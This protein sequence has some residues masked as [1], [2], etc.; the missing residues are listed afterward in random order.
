M[1]SSKDW[2]YVSMLRSWEIYLRYLYFDFLLLEEVCKYTLELCNWACWKYASI[3]F[4][5]NLYPL[6]LYLAKNSIPGVSRES[7]RASIVFLHVIANPLPARYP[8]T[9]LN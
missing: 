4:G 7:A 8:G 1:L 5:G 6:I 3:Q 2:K 9:T